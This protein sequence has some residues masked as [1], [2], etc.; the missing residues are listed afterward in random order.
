MRLQAILKLV[1][2]QNQAHTYSPDAI[3]GFRTN[4][5]STILQAVYYASP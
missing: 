3:Y 4:I 2:I 5:R 1:Y